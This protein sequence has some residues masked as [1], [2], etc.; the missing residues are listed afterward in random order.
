[1]AETKNLTISLSIN[2]SQSLDR[3][4]QYFQ[5]YSIAS[6]SKSDV[7]KYFINEM[8]I[9]VDSGRFDEVRNLL[10]SFKDDSK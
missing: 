1:M 5:K 6:V 2:E 4:V 7:I 10:N 8:V 3:L 9:P